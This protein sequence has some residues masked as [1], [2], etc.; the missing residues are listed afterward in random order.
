[1]GYYVELTPEEKEERNLAKEIERNKLLKQKKILNIFFWIAAGIFIATIITT[2]VLCYINNV[3]TSSNSDYRKS[4]P[5]SAMVLIFV[6]YFTCSGFNIGFNWTINCFQTETIIPV[7]TIDHD[8][9][10]KVLAD[11]TG[12]FAGLPSLLN[13]AFLISIIV[14]LVLATLKRKINMR[15]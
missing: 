9:V 4:Q 11:P 2:I 8:W 10:T 1:M 13:A 14:M 15:L 7:T 5:L 12:N 6:L 3:F